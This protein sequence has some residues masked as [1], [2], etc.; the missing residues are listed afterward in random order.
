MK[1]LLT[2]L[3][4]GLLIFGL[5]NCGS[6]GGGGGGAPAPGPVVTNGLEGNATEITYSAFGPG[7][8]T[9]MWSSLYGNLYFP[10]NNSRCVIGLVQDADNNAS[11]RTQELLALLNA[12]QVVPGTAD[13]T[14]EDLPVLSITFDDGS[15]KTYTLANPSEVSK[16]SEALSNGAEIAN[17]LDTVNNEIS[18]VGTSYCP[19]KGD[20]IPTK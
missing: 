20:S 15:S 7:N 13:Q 14:I 3:C 9:V 16:T 11:V 10:T 2:V 17:F 18:S 4:T 19:G 6:K 8:N 12:A 1:Q 5:A